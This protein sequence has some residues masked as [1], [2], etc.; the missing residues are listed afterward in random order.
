MLGSMLNMHPSILLVPEQFALFYAI[1]R[2]KI[3]NFLDWKD[4]VKI[5]VGEFSRKKASHWDVNIAGIYDLLYEAPL[6]KRCLQ[7]ILDSIYREYGRVTEVPYNIW[8]DKTP[9]NA[10]HIDS[11][12]PVFPKAK[13]V[14]L[15]RDGR[16]V[17]SSYCKS[18][19]EYMGEFSQPD[20]AVMLWNKSSNAFDFLKNNCQA[21]QLHVIRYEDLVETP[22]KMLEAFCAFMGLTFV[23]EMLNFQN[24]VHRMGVANMEHHQNVAK[25]VSSSS[26]GKWESGLTN[27]QKIEFIPKIERNLK[28]WGYV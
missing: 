7:Y 28:R 27:E 9:K 18:K 1:Q 3:L 8:G 20:N 6:E 12:F 23:P 11:I 19:E 15:I 24:E 4:L 2:F 14:F 17:L 5:I 22:Q 13:Y 16:D 10:L 25:K 26:I 21:N